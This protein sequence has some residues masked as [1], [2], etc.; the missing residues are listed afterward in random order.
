MTHPKVLIHVKNH[1]WGLVN[2]ELVIMSM[3]K[4]VS[5]IKVRYHLE[6]WTNTNRKNETDLIFH[7]CCLNIFLLF[8][9]F[10]FLLWFHDLLKIKQKT[11]NKTKKENHDYWMC[12]FSKAWQENFTC[13]YSQSLWS[14][15]PDVIVDQIKGSRTFCTEDLKSGHLSFHG[16]LN[17]IGPALFL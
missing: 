3:I 16:G 7:L 14:L 12:D 4:F 9:G 10:P 11:H 13:V 17:F 6:R 2:L 5:K 15:L 8:S 1:P